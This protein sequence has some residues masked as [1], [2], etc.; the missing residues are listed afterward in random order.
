MNKLRKARWQ[1]LL[2]KAA[3]VNRLIKKNYIVFDHFGHRV[4]KFKFCKKKKLLY[5]GDKYCKV[6]YVGQEGSGWTSALD[7]PLKKYNA[8]SFDKWA[9]VNPKDIK[10]I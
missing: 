7:I 2:K 1:N 3:R 5:R 10:K 4:D 6:V 8:E 9:A